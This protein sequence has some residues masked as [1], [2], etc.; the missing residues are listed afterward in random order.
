MSLTDVQ[1]IT[2]IDITSAAARNA[3]IADFLSEGLEGLRNMTEE[4]V[5]DACSSY[6]KRTD[7]AF[8]IILTP[9]QKQQMKALTLWV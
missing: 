8:P 2:R 5:R 6:T 9:I 1:I 3:I 4:D 7:G